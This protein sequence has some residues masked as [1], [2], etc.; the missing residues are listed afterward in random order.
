MF[1]YL[2]DIRS[3]QHRSEELRWNDR[4][5]GPMPSAPRGCQ[6]PQ[7]TTT[8][9]SLPKLTHMQ[10]QSTDQIIEFF[11]NSRLIIW[12]Q[13]N[14]IYKQFRGLTKDWTQTTRF[15]VS[16]SKHYT[17]MFSVLMWSSNWILLM[18]GWFCPICLIHLIRWK[19]LHSKKNRL[20]EQVLKKVPGKQ[21]PK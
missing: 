3:V 10:S 7:P 14:K 13:Q 2:L 17:R 4:I 15:V 1:W 12:I 16:H 20:A 19:S 5:D 18:H 21:N 8:M 9:T 11:H 6:L